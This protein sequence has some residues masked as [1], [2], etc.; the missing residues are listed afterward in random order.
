MRCIS[1]NVITNLPNVAFDV[2]FKQYSGYLNAGGDGNWKS[3]YWLLESQSDNSTDDP[4]LVWFS[5]GPGTSTVFL[6]FYEFGPFFVS[7]DGD[8]LNENVFAWN[9]YS[10]LLIIDAPIGVG[11]SHDTRNFSNYA[12]D[13][14]ITAIQN[15]NALKDFFQTDHPEYRQREWFI[16]GVSY[17]GVY[18][19]TLVERILQSIGTN[20]FPNTKLQGFALGNPSINQS[21]NINTVMLW[22]AYH[23]TIGIGKWKEMRSSCCGSAPAEECDFFQ[24]I[25]LT[26]NS[27]NK[28]LG[29]RGLEAKDECGR[30]VID[31][32]N[33]PQSR[34]YYQDCY[35]DESDYATQNYDGG[36]K[37]SAYP[38]NY[39]STD[40]QWGYTCWAPKKIERYLNKIEVQ[41]A[42]NVHG[43]W[44]E[45]GSTWKIYNPQMLL[46]Y[47][48]TLYTS[49]LFK[50]I[51]DH[52]NEFQGKV[53]KNFRILV[54]HGDLD[55]IC[56]FLG[57][58]QY[59]EKVAE[60]NSFVAG[61]R[62]AWKFR[63]QVAGFSQRYDKTIG[64][65]NRLSIDVLTVK[66]G[67]H[68]AA[69]ERPGPCLQMIT[70]FLRGSANY[71]SSRNFDACP[72]QRGN[73]NS[74]ALKIV[75]IPMLTLFAIFCILL[76]Q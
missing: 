70:N 48:P 42:L 24:H 27:S 59:M 10:N 26:T 31:T 4:L 22:H 68:T 60:E 54:Y 35:L 44:I 58:A 43:D 33:G 34:D 37:Q 63:N 73:L 72:S 20:Q 46:D 16:G 67:L 53:A 74:A 9:K 11:F 38:L 66:G 19:P 13:D 7:R 21:I 41:K 65:G 50:Q 45:S 64:V 39:D 69:R 28:Y 55:T 8:G 57:G 62:V 40:N 5:G 15:L 17:G 49:N 2:N 3:F 14:D 47:N 25:S 56:N 36:T 71:S 75:H 30:L 32:L 61:Q 6:A 76:V 29:N 51:F 1:S 52:L 18:V 12:T 23:G